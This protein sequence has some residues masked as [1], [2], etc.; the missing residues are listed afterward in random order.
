[1]VDPIRQLKPGAPAPR[2]R[3]QTSNALE[4]KVAAGQSMDVRVEKIQNGYIT[5]TSQFNEQAGEWVDQA[6]YSPEEPT[7]EVRGVPK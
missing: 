4:T 7:I 1:M 3:R 5:R 2:S 6:V